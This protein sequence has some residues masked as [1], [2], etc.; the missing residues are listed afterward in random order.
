MR[1]LEIGTAGSLA[2]LLLALALAGAPAAS[3][4]SGG[5]GGTLPGG[6]G[7][8]AHGAGSHGGGSDN[9]F[10]SFGAG[11]DFGRRGG[12]EFGRND[13]GGD[14]NGHDHGFDGHDHGPDGHD[15]N[16]DFGF[17]YNGAHW[18]GFLNGDGYSG[19]PGIALFRRYGGGDYQ[20]CLRRDVYND[21]YYAC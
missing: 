1:T 21:L 4:E 9:H 13:G 12:G 14:R 8:G 15:R 11:G 6:G 18:G 10:G 2:A 7:M 19:L 5:Q 20:W 16:P 3:A 17:G